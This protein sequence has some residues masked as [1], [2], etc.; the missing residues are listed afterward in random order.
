LNIK[1]GPVRYWNNSGQTR[2]SILQLS[3]ELLSIGGG[4]L[5]DFYLPLCVKRLIMMDAFMN[6]LSGETA[7]VG[8]TVQNW[9][10]VV[11]AIIGFWVIALARGL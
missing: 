11:A 9:M 8:F 10:L 3:R 1:T 7:I 2:A 6:F 4:K 5:W